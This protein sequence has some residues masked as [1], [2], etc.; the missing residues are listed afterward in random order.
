[1]IFGGTPKDA[2]GVDAQAIIEQV[3]YAKM[4]PHLKEPINQAH[5]E[6]SMYEQIEADLERELELSSLEYPDENQINTT[7]HKQQIVGNQDNT[8]NINS[9]TNDSNAN[10]N[11]NDRKSKTVFSICEIPGET[12]HS[13]EKFFVGANAVNRPLPWNRKPQPQD[14]QDSVTGCVRATAQY[15]N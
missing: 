15:L 14:A 5:L 8:G 10:N 6:K 7:T 12:N 1:M 2:F 11:K 13:A 9:D 3:I 4:P